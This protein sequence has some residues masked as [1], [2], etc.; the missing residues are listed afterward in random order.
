MSFVVCFVTRVGHKARK[1]PNLADGLS[2]STA[3]GEKELSFVELTQ[4]G[5]GAD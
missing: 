1:C 5:Q 3:A 4:G 2:L